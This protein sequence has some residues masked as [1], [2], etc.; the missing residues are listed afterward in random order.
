MK[1][2][3]ILMPCILKLQSL[4]NWFGYSKASMTSHC[5]QL[6]S[7]LVYIFISQNVQNQSYVSWILFAHFSRK[8]DH[9]S[10]LWGWSFQG[11]IIKVLLYLNIYTHYCC[12]DKVCHISYIVFNCFIGLNQACSVGPWHGTIF[13]HLQQLFEI[14]A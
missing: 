9:I 3:H 13:L 14:R 5:I 2:Q 11:F 8:P 10:I 6:H 12:Y 4:P 7:K 1:G